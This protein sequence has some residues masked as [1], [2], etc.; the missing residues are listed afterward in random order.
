MILVTGGAG[1]IG[2]HIALALRD[3]GDAV[4]V[5]DDLSA[6]RRWMV[7][8]GAVF[9]EGDC[10][11]RALVADS[12]RRYAIDTVIHCA[13]VFCVPE[14]VADPLRY[15]STNVAAAVGLFAGAI[16]GGARHLLFSSTGTVYGPQDSAILF[17]DLPLA[18]AS[19]YA[20]SKAM[21]ERILADIAAT[22][23]A[24][25]GVL[26]YFNVA[27]A[28]RA[29]RAGQV[30]QPATQ[31]IQIAAEAA[32]GWRDHVLVTGSDF[33]TPDG[34]GIRDYV[35]VADLAGAHLAAVAALRRAP[36]HS[37]TY[38]VGYGRGLSVTQMLDAVDR[39]NGA[40][41]RRVMAPRRPGDVARLVADPA[42]IRA[43][44]G[45]Q[46]VHDDLDA[47]IADALAWQRQLAA[48]ND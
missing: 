42:R 40:R 31:I 6:G 17:E 24:N 16:A 48:R 11:D 38:N 3:R 39:V 35:H 9:I 22:G 26:R 28:D 14:S 21:V 10:A 27:G 44:L 29:G 8:D 47:M 34:T 41:L 20:A 33:A 43:A 12:V 15:Y 45:W 37:F 1:Y 13:G 32:T 5:L 30:S 46:P 2:A 7:P 18:P 36:D 4:V 25:M 19:P 23:A